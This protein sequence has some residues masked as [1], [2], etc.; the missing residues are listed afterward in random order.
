MKALKTIIMMALI[1]GTTVDAGTKVRVDYDENASFEHLRQYSWSDH[2]ND[3][4]LDQAL[5]GPLVSERIRE[6]IDIELASLGYEKVD[7]EQADFLIDYHLSTEEK[8]KVT[9]F[10][11]YY[12]SSYYGHGYGHS[13]GH[14]YGRSYGHGY[15][16]SYGHGYGGGYGHGYGG[17]YGHGYGGG[18]GHG[19]GYADVGYIAA[20]IVREFLEVTLTLDI[21]EAQTGAVIW[22]GWAIKS[23]DQHPK[24]KKTRKFIKRS[25]HKI[26]K[27]FPAEGPLS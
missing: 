6:E 3:N 4:A 10:D 12:G 11:N 22:R 18:Y 16:Q 21:I 26:L 15:G 8:T 25:V 17:G 20:P 13:Y 5:S 19:Y 14:G 7:A 1:I 2:V 9:T 24:P 23:L 27:K